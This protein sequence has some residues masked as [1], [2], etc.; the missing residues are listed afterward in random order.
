MVRHDGRRR[1]REPRRSRGSR[2]SSTPSRSTAAW[3]ASIA[4]RAS[5]STSSLRLARTTPPLTLELGLAADHQPA[6][7]HPAVL[8]GAARLPQR[9]SGQTPGSRSAAD[10]TRQID[11]NTLK[12][13]GRVWGPDAVAKNAS[14]SFYGNIVSL[15]ESPAKE[16]L[17]Y[18]GTDDGLVQVTEDGGQTWRHVETF[19]GVPERTYVS[20][21]EPSPRRPGHRVR[22]V[23]QPQDGRLQAVPAEE[24]RPRPDLDV[25]RRQPAGARHRVRGRRGSRETPTCCSPAPSSASSSPLDGG[26]NWVQMKG[27][28]PTIAVRDLAIQKR[29]SDLVLATF[30]R[31]FYVLDDYSPLRRVTPQRPRTARPRCSRSSTAWMFIPSQP[32][33]LARQGLP[34]RGLLCGADNPPFGAVFTYYLKDELKTKRKARQ[35]QREEGGEGGRRR[36]LPHRGTRCAPRSGR[37]RRR[38]SSRSPTTTA[39]S[40]GG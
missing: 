24:H 30:G 40:C 8:R 26:K 22:R 38:S 6:L 3:C 28:V 14:T 13:M 1:V 20:R 9:R 39:T 23:R 32:L 27:G 5:R 2:T 25:D 10:L 15:A 21:L 19:P 37:S 4:G 31:G 33:R 29:E 35:D 36:R 18:V 12:V 11:R 16:G 17:L 7:A 34:G